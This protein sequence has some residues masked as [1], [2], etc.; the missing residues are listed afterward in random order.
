MTKLVNALADKALS[1]FLPQ[2][3]AGA[4]CSPYCFYYCGTDGNCREECI[5]GTCHVNAYFIHKGCGAP[6]C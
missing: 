1:M 6:H 4:T 3:T 5:T 2:A